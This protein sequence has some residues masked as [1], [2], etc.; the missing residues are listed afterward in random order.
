MDG[1][2]RNPN[3]FKVLDTLKARLE[4][5]LSLDTSGFSD[6]ELEAWS[7]VLG[8]PGIDAGKLPKLCI[9]TNKRC[10]KL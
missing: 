7:L 1:A 9:T 5:I 3:I 2:A 6:D 4:S 8:V 10:L